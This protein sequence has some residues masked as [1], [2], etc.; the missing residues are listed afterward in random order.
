[1]LKFF[2]KCQFRFW[3]TTLNIN[4]GR[5][6]KLNKS[7]GKVGLGEEKSI[8]HE[9]TRLSCIWGLSIEEAEI[10]ESRPR[11]KIAFTALASAT[12]AQYFASQI[13]DFHMNF[14]PRFYLVYVLLKLTRKG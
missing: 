12:H 8:E 2:K 13:L 5:I 9:S 11:S 6:K 10:G 14:S 3:R 1:M 7:D 4:F